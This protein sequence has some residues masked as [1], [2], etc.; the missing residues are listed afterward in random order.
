MSFALLEIDSKTA[1]SDCV[2]FHYSRSMPDNVSACYR[3]V[4]NG[5][6]IGSIVFGYG[7]SRNIGSPFGVDNSAVNE[8]VRVA[9]SGA[10]AHQTSHYLSAAVKRFFATHPSIGVLIS[11]ADKN[12]GHSGA[13]YRACNWFYLGEF[14]G[15]GN[16]ILLNGVVT[17]CR[18]VG[19][20]YGTRSITW[21]RENVDENCQSI[22]LLGKHKFCIFRDR[23][24]RKRLLPRIALA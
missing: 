9:L 13:L 10:Q 5:L 21:L 7:A 4:E 15:A 1:R 12:Q 23:R 8:L 14:P 24:W 16:A 20:T 3:V 19:S 2:A 11:Y 6:A 22:P 18:S 17:H